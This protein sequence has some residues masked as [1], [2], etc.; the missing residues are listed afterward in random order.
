MRSCLFARDN[1]VYTLCTQ[2]QMPTYLI[3]WQSEQN[4][5]TKK[6]SW[7]PAI[8]KEVHHKPSTGMRASRQGEIAVLTSDGHVCMLEAASLSE[9]TSK[10][11]PHVMPITS[12]VFSGS[13]GDRI[14]TAGLDYKYCILPK[15]SSSWLKFFT[16]LLFNM[17][18]F[19]VL[20]LYFAEWF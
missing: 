7:K 3:R 10:R 9:T 6:F 16:T 19:L 8:T 2:A 12:L 18:F 5:K 11:R 13:D 20:L 1:S 15:T 4:D 17:G 14:I